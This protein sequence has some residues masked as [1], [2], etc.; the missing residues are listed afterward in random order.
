MPDSERT[1]NSSSRRILKVVAAVLLAAAGVVVGWLA[2]GVVLSLPLPKGALFALAGL[3]AVGTL[4]G[5]YYWGRWWARA[6][7]L[8]GFVGVVVSVALVFFVVVG[9]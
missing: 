5:A 8:G 9:S 6:L 4:V 2:V 7:L 3:V 1:P